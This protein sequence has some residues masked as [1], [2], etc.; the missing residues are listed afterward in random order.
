MSLSA[1]EAS[2][3]TTMAI[4]NGLGTSALP[5]QRL[6][7]RPIRVLR[8]AQRQ[9]SGDRRCTDRTGI[10]QSRARAVVTEGTH[11]APHGRRVGDPGGHRGSDQPSRGAMGRRRLGHHSS[12]RWV[13]SCSRRARLSGRGRAAPPCPGT[14][15]SRRWRRSMP[16]GSCGVRQVLDRAWPYPSRSGEHP[17]TG[18]ATA[19]AIP[20][21]S[22]PR[23]RSAAAVGSTADRSRASRRVRSGAP[24]RRHRSARAPG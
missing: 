21:L 12:C 18:E 10:A 5:H 16:I 23:A 24:S 6:R 3:T 14:A 19:M 22:P 13:G 2:M 15:M 1:R 8:R 7:W 17:W 11:A 9:T 4:E 20:G